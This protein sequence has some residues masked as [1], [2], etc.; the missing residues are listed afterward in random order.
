MAI[1]IDRVQLL[2]IP[3]TI[4]AALALWGGLAFLDFPFATG[5]EK[6]LNYGAYIAFLAALATFTFERRPDEIR[7]RW[8]FAPLGCVLLLVLAVVVFAAGLQIR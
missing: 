8:I 6:Y 5:F 3:A 2:M 1:R 7:R 4:G